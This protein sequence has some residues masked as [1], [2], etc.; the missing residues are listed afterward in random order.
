MCSLSFLTAKKRSEGGWGTRVPDRDV[1]RVYHVV[2][3]RAM[4]PFVKRPRVKRRR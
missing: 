4:S 3:S 1:L 2:G